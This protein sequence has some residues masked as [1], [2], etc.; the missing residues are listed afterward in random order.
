MRIKFDSNG[1]EVLSRIGKEIILTIRTALKAEGPKIVA[2]AKK[3]MDAGAP[4]TSPADNAL[5]VRSGRL[6]RSVKYW[7]EGD[8]MVVGAGSGA[9]WDYAKIHETGQPSYIVPRRAQWLTIPTEKALGSN[10]LVSTKAKAYKRSGALIGLFP[11]DKP[12]IGYLVKKYGSDQGVWFFLR[13]R[14]PYVGAYPSRPYLKDP[15]QR[16]ADRLR[17]SLGMKFHVVPR[18]Q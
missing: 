2:D 12:D 13:K 14:V 4:P 6:Q 15:A 1:D 16:G 10:G 9:S 5:S 8:S 18:Y 3:G 11:K 17:R 7:M